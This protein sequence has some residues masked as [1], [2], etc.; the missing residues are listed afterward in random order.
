MVYILSVIHATI[1]FLLN[2]TRHY[3]WFNNLTLSFT[4]MSKQVLPAHKQVD[5]INWWCCCFTFCPDNK[6][7][8]TH[9]IYAHVRVRGDNCSAREVYSLARQVT[10]ETSLLPLQPLHKSSSIFLWLQ[11]KQEMKF[12]PYHF[13]LFTVCTG[14][15]LD[16]DAWMY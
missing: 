2:N 16:L 4:S 15:G 11:R 7:L 1:F 5:L 12:L 14:N 10:T 9:L 13:N 3:H 6:S 8:S